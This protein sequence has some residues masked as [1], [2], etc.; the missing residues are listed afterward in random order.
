MNLLERPCQTNRPESCPL[1]RYYLLLPHRKTAL[2]H[3]WRLLPSRASQLLSIID[4]VAGRL[5]EIGTADWFIVV[6]S[7]VTDHGAIM[8]Y[9]D[10]NGRELASQAIPLYRLSTPKPRALCCLGHRA[11]GHHAAR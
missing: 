10:G 9:Q 3:R 8:R 5:V 2:A 4:A 7:E 1:Y 11:L 6:R